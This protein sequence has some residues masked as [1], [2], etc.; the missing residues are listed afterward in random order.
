M[1][2]VYA[3]DVDNNVMLIIMTYTHVTLHACLHG[4]VVHM[5]ACKNL[6]N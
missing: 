6:S 3:H 4:C 5:Q 2:G 1:I